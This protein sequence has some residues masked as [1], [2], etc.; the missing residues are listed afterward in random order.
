MSAVKYALFAAGG[1]DGSSGCV[2][3]TIPI[4]NRQSVPTFSAVVKWNEQGQRSEQR[5]IMLRLITGGKARS[6]AIR[7]KRSP[8]RP[9]WTTPQSSAL[10]LP[11]SPPR[12]PYR[13][14]DR[15]PSSRRSSRAASP[16]P[17]NPSAGGSRARVRSTAGTNSSNTPRRRDCVCRRT[18]TPREPSRSWSAPQ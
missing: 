1:S 14:D 16:P 17:R 11:P 7:A 3:S 4:Q 12:Y 5:S 13:G 8:P 6:I 9:A 18:D 15:R 2:F 10:L